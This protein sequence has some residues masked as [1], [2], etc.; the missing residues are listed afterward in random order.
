MNKTTI[1]NSP[2][3]LSARLN[4][5]TGKLS[6]EELERHYA[7]GVVVKVA[8]GLDLVEVAAH[9]VRD[10]KAAVEAWLASGQVARA[11]AEDARRWRD[12]NAALW[13]VVAAP[14]VVVQEIVATNQA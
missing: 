10:D 8:I 13:A 2:A 1:D 6:W 5:E 11:S 9:I 12:S 3:T 4:A 14:W 7:R